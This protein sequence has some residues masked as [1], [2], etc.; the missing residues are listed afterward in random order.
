MTTVARLALF[1]A[2]GV[3]SSALAHAESCPQKYPRANWAVAVYSNGDNNLEDH[4]VQDLFEFSRIGSS[5]HRDPD[6]SGSA[7]VHVVVQLDTKRWYGGGT[8]RI[9]VKKNTAHTAP[10]MQAGPPTWAGE[11]WAANPRWES[12]MADGAVLRD[13]I[14]DTLD[15]YPSDHIALI[16]NGHGMGGRDE[17]MPDDTGMTARSFGR[18][19]T[20]D[21]SDPLYVEEVV[22]A[23]EQASPYRKLDL[24]GLDSCLMSTIE[25]GFAFQ[26]VATRLVA[27]EELEGP[28]GWAHHSW[29]EALVSNPNADGRDLAGLIV[30]NY[31]GAMNQY[32]GA[33]K[34][35]WS[36]AYTLTR[37]EL[38]EAAPPLSCTHGGAT[39]I[40]K[41]LNLVAG[42]VRT[43]ALQKEWMRARGAC[44]CFG[45]TDEPVNADLACL[46][47]RFDEQ[48]Q[49]LEAQP[50][51]V[52]VRG[53]VD[54]ALEQINCATAERSIAPEL[55]NMGGLS[56]FFPPTRHLL[57][58]TALGR[59]TEGATTFPV[60]FFAAAPKWTQLLRDRAAG[61][62]EPMLVC[63]WESN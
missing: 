41:A 45:P 56:V 50:R 39:G 19:D 27:S 31:A 60:R 53:A 1:T 40:T 44:R 13:F 34:S 59:A 35:R 5:R 49:P 29:L 23:I 11:V 42:H 24:V 55:T 9:H 4:I 3:S 16:I 7:G 2:L 52:D 25:V 30:A 10:P 8:Y 48:L 58:R 38:A 26:R 32:T 12:N 46:L 17:G 33:S 20:P 37:T 18:D 61:T 28:D 63:D 51:I 62:P 21:R 54:D 15:C 14:K 57:E 6:A 47:R 36:S 43:E 22:Q